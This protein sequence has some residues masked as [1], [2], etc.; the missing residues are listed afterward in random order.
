MIVL[1]III[2]VPILIGILVYFYFTFIFSKRIEKE[3]IKIKEKIRQE[4]EHREK[5]KIKLNE[6]LIN[7]CSLFAIPLE[8]KNDLGEAAGHILY[9]KD[10]TGR[11][12]L[13]D[14]KIEVLE[15]YQNSPWVLGHELG[16]YIA[17]KKH[18]NNSEE[19]ADKMAKELCCTLLSE[20]EQ[21][22]IKLSLD[23]YFGDL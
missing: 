19:L 23:S 17:L 16:H 18:Q 8:Y 22:A 11:I 7:L 12:L 14:C 1:A 15:R 5:T 10:K 21:K 6:K 2:G 20:K 9:H 3:L 13:D 4:E